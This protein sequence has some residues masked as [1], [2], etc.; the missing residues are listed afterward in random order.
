MNLPC[1]LSFCRTTQ[2]PS[3]ELSWDTGPKSISSR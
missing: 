3:Y 2:A 1:R